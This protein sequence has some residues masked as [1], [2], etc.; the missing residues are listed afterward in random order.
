MN[1]RYMHEAAVPGGSVLNRK[2]LLDCSFAAGEL[3][4]VAGC[5]GSGKSTLLQLLAGLRP[6]GSGS[7][8]EWRGEERHPL[9][10]QELLATSSYVHQNPEQM[11]F[12]PTVRDEILYS[13][14]KRKLPP[15]ERRE[16]MVWAAARCG[17]GE[18]LWERS[19][20]TLS[21][22]EKRRTA[23]AAAAALR[24]PWLI[25]DEPTAG[26]D[27]V[28]AAS[29]AGEM[30]EWK[31]E[32]GSSGGGI[33]IASHELDLFLPLADRVVLLKNGSVTG[34]WS[35]KELLKDPSPLTEAGLGVPDNIRLSALAGS[36]SL[37]AEAIARSLAERLAAGSTAMAAQLDAAEAHESRTTEPGKVSVKTTGTDDVVQQ[38]VFSGA[39]HRQPN[40]GTRFTRLSGLDPRAK[41]LLYALFSVSLLISPHWGVTTL[42]G[43]AVA[44][45]GLAAG[46]PAKRWL[47]PVFAF[48]GFILAAFVISGVELSF[49]RGQNP[50]MHIGFSWEQG[51][52]T[53]KRLAPLLPVLAGGVLFN[54]LTP[55]LSIQK[56]LEEL[57]QRI[58]V[59][60]R[61]G[62]TIGLAVALLFR[63]IRF[64]P[65][66]L[67][68]MALLASVRG[69]PGKGSPGKLK[70]H[71]LPV[72]FI[73]LLLSMLHHAEEL[74]FALMARGYGRKG[75]KRT[76]A[77]PL[78][79]QRSDGAACLAGVLCIAGMNALRLFF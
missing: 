53:L 12:L 18:E 29:L 31:R 24:Q 67:G 79:W 13:L 58:P 40:H 77:V 59:L 51:Q 1:G 75:A 69:R 16:R 60:R 62:D 5:T 55:P 35:P 6:A 3:T 28:M 73:P 20:F 43:A 61:A 72:F 23:L 46:I 15:Q 42:G 30:A 22:G 19:A 10:R 14:Q 65:G 47:R 21:G 54:I 74:S 11:F 48:A 32:Q 76:K 39:D 70:L 57:L 4:L 38:P 26:L 9:E 27:P 66:E 33:I 41:W 68:R 37:A 45:L 64:L 7:I 63:F 50:L 56:G 25:L 52:I 34:Q 71:Q 36:D 78:R 8:G 49:A 2:G 17:L 44:A